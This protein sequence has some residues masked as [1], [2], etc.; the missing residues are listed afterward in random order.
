MDSYFN[1]PNTLIDNVFT[2]EEISKIYK[3]NELMPKQYSRRVEELG[4]NALHD[5]LN[6]EISKKI[7]IL[8][9]SI[10]NK[11]LEKYMV[12]FASYTNDKISHPQLMPHFDTELNFATVS[13]S[14][15]LKST[16]DWDISVEGKTFQIKNNQG[17]TFSGSHQWHWRPNIE[18]KD[19]DHYDILVCQY[20]E[21]GDIYPITDEHK[22]IMR[23]KTVELVENWHFENPIG[24]YDDRQWLLDN[25]VNGD[26]ELSDICEKYQLGSSV[27]LRFLSKHQIDLK[28]P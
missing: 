25:Y 22:Q 8:L 4:Y 13:I 15:A 20:K 23:L 9:E 27:I 10:S 18:F 19:N 14:I 7:Q 3:N 24:P 6:D 17:V 11:K 26:L 28:L 12:H 5:P 2:D 16:I 1:I 21:I